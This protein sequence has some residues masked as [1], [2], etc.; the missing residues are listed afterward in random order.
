MYQK[1]KNLSKSDKNWEKKDDKE[2]KDV[3]MLGIF[4]KSVEIYPKYKKVPKVSK[5][6]KIKKYQQF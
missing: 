3:K 2:A 4:K 6:K 1:H 5:Y